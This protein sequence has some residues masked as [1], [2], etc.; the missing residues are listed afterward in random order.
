MTVNFG[1]IH[2]VYYNKYKHPQIQ[3]SNVENLNLWVFEID[4]FRASLPMLTK[5]HN[6]DRPTKM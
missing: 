6:A 1:P 3:A 2:N 4:Y 5:S